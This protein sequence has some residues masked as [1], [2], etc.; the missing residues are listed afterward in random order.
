MFTS[1]REEP[2]H[3]YRVPDRI[4]HVTL[5]NG[6]I[7]N[8]AC[9]IFWY[10]KKGK[11]AGKKTYGFQSKMQEYPNDSNKCNEHIKTVSSTLKIAL[12]S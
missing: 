11:V 2:E 7:S 8:Y 12:W 9:I 10:K 4:T 6:K 3:Y 5:L 1:Y